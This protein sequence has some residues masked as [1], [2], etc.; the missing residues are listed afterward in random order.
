MINFNKA[1]VPICIFA[2]I[3][4][5][6]GTSCKKFLQVQ[7]KDY[8]F[9]EDAFST[10][11]GVESALNGI[12]QSMADSLLY[13]NMLTLNA[14]EQMAQ[15]YK[16]ATGEVSNFAYFTYVN[17]FVKAT[18]ETVWTRSYH[19]ILGVNNFCVKLED[20]SFAVV[21]SEERNIMLGEAY[22]IR[23]YMHF[24]LLRLYGPVYLKTP[25]DPAIPYYRSVARTP[26]PIL[27]ATNAIN[28]VVRDLN[29]ALELLKNDPIR[30]KGPDWSNST[31]PGQAIDYL[32]N[33]QR[34]MNY[35]AV[36]AVLARVLLY[37]GK[38][39]D[40]WNT[41]QSFMAEQEQFFPWYSEANFGKD[42]LLSKES[43]FGIGNRSLYNSYRQLFS[44]TLSND[45]IYAPTEARLNLLYP[46]LSD[47]RLKYWFTPGVDGNK[48]YK[49]FVKF[50]NASISDQTLLYYQPL[51]RKAELYLMAAE[52]SP[53]LAKGYGFL[54]TLRTNRGLA[55][56]TYNASTSSTAELLTKIR[57]EY[58]KEF[59]GEG[60]TI[61]LY[62]RLNASPIPWIVDG[63]L[64]KYMTVQQY[65]WP[66]PES[67]AY[68]R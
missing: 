49:V 19:L 48:T 14:T 1:V 12:Y 5:T 42:P 37:A 61:F 3:L 21:N 25:Q 47:L 46:D 38:K 51:I 60:Q 8:I 29:V 67:E 56:V 16:P 4:T 54:N 13:G 44:P 11:K 65:I 59:I 15:Y 28:E 57:E 27:S 24:D 41:I 30:T 7:P 20:P 64:S 45:V 32:S 35:Y 62:K 34:R 18:L 23:A 31:V 43:F 9:E 53:D 39:A 58:Q 26:E 33:R 52:T 50:N 63:T 22:A 36:K 68:Y 10:P 40:S 55:Q 17:P 2:V 66:R 6:L